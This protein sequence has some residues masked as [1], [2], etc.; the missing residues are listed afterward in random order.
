LGFKDRPSLEGEE[1]LEV[2]AGVIKKPSSFS[3]SGVLGNSIVLAL[4][5]PMTYLCIIFRSYKSSVSFRVVTL[6][7]NVRIH[8]RLFRL[9]ALC[10]NLTRTS[11]SGFRVERWEER[12][13]AL[14]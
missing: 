9:I 13:E 11:P 12:E 8:C 5:N 7:N 6:P 2:T 4:P 1:A 3:D 10:N 14:S